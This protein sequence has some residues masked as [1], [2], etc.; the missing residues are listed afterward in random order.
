MSEA[1]HQPSNTRS[2]LPPIQRMPRVKRSMNRST[3]MKPSSQVGMQCM[4]GEDGKF[5]YIPIDPY[6]Q[7]H[8]VFINEMSPLLINPTPRQFEK[9]AVYT[10]IVASIIR[11]NPDTNRDVVE[12]PMKL[13]VCKAHNMFEF[14]TKHHQ[15]FYRMV[16]TDELNDI[17]REKGIDARQ[18]QYALYASGEIKCIDPFTLL[19]NFFSG[20]Y[21]MQNHVTTKREQIEIDIISDKLKEIDPNYVIR[22]N[23]RPFI[24]TETMSATHRQLHSLNEKGIP[25][26]GFETQQQ[27]RQMQSQVWSVKNVE[28]RP[29]TQDEMREIHKKITTSYSNGLFSS[30]VTS[31]AGMNIYAMT[32]PE[33]IAHAANL[34]VSISPD[35]DAHKIRKI[36]SEHMKPKGKGG[37]KKTIKKKH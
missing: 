9:G 16:L 24:V 5:Y 3:I 11:K 32:T 6:S 2:G 23:S 14:G 19:F 10:Y 29:M 34:N 12:V 20:T 28:K 7:E 33:L 27:C 37:R 18:L 25:T 22:L 30:A 35:D 26:F 31:T 1:W 4:K 36:I 15:I 13:Y 8:L 21:K 17:A